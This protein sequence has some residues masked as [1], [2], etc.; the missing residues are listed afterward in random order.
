MQLLFDSFIQRFPQEL[1]NRLKTAVAH[2]THLNPVERLHAGTCLV[3]KEQLAEIQELRELQTKKIDI[4]SSKNPFNIFKKTRMKKRIQLQIKNKLILAKENAFQLASLSGYL[5]PLMRATKDYL[6]LLKQIEH[7]YVQLLYTYFASGGTNNQETREKIEENIKQLE[8]HPSYN[9]EMRGFVCA[10][11]S[12]LYGTIGDTMVLKSIFK[13]IRE[14]LPVTENIVEIRGLQDAA[15]NAIWWF[16]HSGV[17]SNIDEMISFLEPFILK[18]K[19]Y[20]SYTDFLNLKGAVNSY[21]GNTAESIENFTQLMNEHEKYHNDYR[22]S[23]AIGNLAESF[24]AEGKIVKAKEMMERAIKLYKES[25]GR[26]PYLYLTE[27]GNI[28]Y[29]MNDPRA[30]KS[31]LQAFEIKKNET[32][33]F[34]AF[35]LFELIHFYLRTEQLDKVDAYLKE[36][37]FLAREL[38]TLSVNASLDYLLGFN[39]MLQQN[40]S[41]AIKYLQSSLEQAHLSK[42]SDLILSNNILLAAIHLQRYR[43]NEKDEELNNALNYLE[44]AIKL[45]EEFDH[46]QVLAIGLVIRAY[47]NASKGEFS[48]AFDDL[49]QIK[50]ISDRMDFEQWKQEYQTVVDLVVKGEKE[51]KLKVQEETIFKYILPQIKSMLSFKLPERKHRKSIVLGLLVINDSGIP[52]FTKLSKNLE[53]DKLILSGLITAISHFSESIISGKDKGR[54]REILYEGIWLTTQPVKN[55]LV[56]VIAEEATAEIRIWASSIANRIKEVPAIV[57]MKNELTIDIDDILKQMNFS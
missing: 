2:Q 42:N 54:L 9:H 32:S 48:K 22:L 39:D 23:I 6:T 38:E 35:I 41:Y 24:S 27:I 55:G 51:G 19:L 29:L 16:L 53:T 40:F 30:E 17:E 45:A 7:P 21:F 11:R 47:L 3:L 10:I 50:E 18:Y 1:R 26:W 36:M 28:Y 20:M 49:E 52:V 46:V 57:E 44:T 37:R 31:F 43:I 15:T 8:Q 4:A 14:R 12:W 33:L 34:K 25:T 5:I 13:Y 56:V